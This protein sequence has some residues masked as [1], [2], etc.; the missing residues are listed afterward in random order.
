[1]YSGIRI[2]AYLP[3]FAYIDTV[4]Y[5]HTWIPVYPHILI[6]L[7]TGM[8]VYKHS[9]AWIG[10][11]ISMHTHEQPEIQI[12]RYRDDKRIRETEKTQKRGV[13][14]I[15]WPDIGNNSTKKGDKKD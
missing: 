6:G 5:V 9:N 13:F 3:I 15:Y 4:G 11:S 2:F 14:R 1:M 10:E 12:C 8:Q 7:Y